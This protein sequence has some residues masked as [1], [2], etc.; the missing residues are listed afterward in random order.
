MGKHLEKSISVFI[1][2]VGVAIYSITAFSYMYDKFVSKDTMTLIKEKLDRIDLK[3][4]QLGDSIHD[5][6]IKRTRATDRSR[7]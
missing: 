2:L 3:L 4:D 1:L 6:K 5:Y 7:D